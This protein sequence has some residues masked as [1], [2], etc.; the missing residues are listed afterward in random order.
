M[1]PLYKYNFIG[2]LSV[3]IALIIASIWLFWWITNI[4]EEITKG[5]AYGLDIGESKAAVFEKLISIYKDEKVSVIAF[6]SEDNFKTKYPVYYKTKQ[7]NGFPLKKNIDFLH[8]YI[9]TNKLERKI[10]KILLPFDGWNLN[11]GGFF[12]NG[13]HLYFEEGKLKNIRR[14]RTIISI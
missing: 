4:D 12:K 13:L 11:W 8:I 3:S 7:I 6:I 2:L 10:L 9:P 5:N 14:I 1:K